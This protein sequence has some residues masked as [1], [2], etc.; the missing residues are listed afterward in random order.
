MP[1]S[2]E[3]DVPAR[4]HWL[5]GWVLL[6][7]LLAVAANADCRGGGESKAGALDPKAGVNPRSLPVPALPD[8]T[9]MAPSVQKQV[10][11][12]YASLKAAFATTPATGDRELAAEFGAMG[13]VLMAA[14][15][16][17]PAE[18][19]FLAAQ[20][21]DPDD[22]RWPYYLG[23]VSRQ[24]GDTDKAAAWFERV[25][26]LQPDDVPALV[27]LGEIY[28]DQG[29]AELAESVWTKALS[30]QPGLFA[31]R[32]GLGRGALARGQFEA[33]VKHLEAALTIDSR[34]SI[35]HYPLALAYRALGR[36]G[37]AESHLRARGESQ[38]GLPDPLLQ[39]IA[40]LLR[41]AVVYEKRGD[42][43]LARGDFVAAVAAFR[44]GLELAPDRLAIRQK[45]ATALALS[46]DVPGAVEQYR[47][48]LRRAPDFAEAHYSLGVLFLGNNQLDLAIERFAV[49]VRADPTYLQARLQLATALRRSGRLEAA[50]GQYR[51]ALDLEPRL[52]E[53][54][55]GYAIALVGLQRYAAAKTWLDESRRLHPD[56]L[57][58][59]EAMVRLT[60][61][62]PD[63]GVRDGRRALQ[64]GRELV[65]K[66][67]TWST[68]EA[69]AMALAEAGQYEEAAVQQ[70]E[71]IRLLQ[72]SAH[73]DP[74]R[75][76]DNLHLYQQLRPCRTPWIDDS[77]WIA[78][79]TATS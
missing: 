8:V 39:E 36:V 57:E 17:E 72:T 69:L 78:A 65:A 3:P 73:S 74:K 58:F 33:A 20:W 55:F 21:L 75:M 48:V 7:L 32:F 79:L 40:T 64:L 47:E 68:L 70:R 34:A 49:A 46:G 54:R 29:R 71:A 41:S 12:Q 38:P 43:A 45:L 19:H 4:R 18:Q 9:R 22:R 10:Q 6:A 60:A 26:L 31:A 59:G 15:S 28:L 25:L 27:W 77:I 37:E 30:Q 35:V 24:R 62:A 42:G 52:E 53:A 67:R 14:E 66:R 13:R 2:H 16:P 76:L 61:A 1:V 63:A 11:D 56:R 5:S 44:S 50:L 51:E 23:H